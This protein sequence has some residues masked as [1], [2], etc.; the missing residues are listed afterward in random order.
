M[1]RYLYGASVQG[2]QEFIFATNELKSIIGASEIVKRIN[3]TIKEKYEKN[4]VV[5]AAGNVKLIF[6]ENE[7]DILEKLVLD[8]PKKIMKEAFGITLS[9][10]VVKF[11]TGELKDAFEKLEKNLFI[12][13]NKP[14]I[15]LDSSINILKLASKTAKPAVEVVKD[16]HK[17]MATLQK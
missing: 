12:Q 7:K 2:I 8:F 9:Q 6:D 15:P 13:R 14:S 1:S 10:A 17:D 16:E 5:N 11:E 3:D 4:I